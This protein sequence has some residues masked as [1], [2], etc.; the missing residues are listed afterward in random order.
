MRPSRGTNGARRAR[1]WFGLS[2]RLLHLR[3][4]RQ[5]VRDASATASAWIRA[6]AVR[7]ARVS[8]DPT[9]DESRSVPDNLA[10]EAIAAI[11]VLWEDL[12]RRHAERGS[13]TGDATGIT[14]LAAVNAMRELV[15]HPPLRPQHL[16]CAARH[17]TPYRH[18]IPA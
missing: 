10:N 1:T 18:G 17:A 2:M 13:I 9:G 14:L 12:A 4:D 5:S 6:E 16:A 3:C 15:G 8:N 7:R 11:N